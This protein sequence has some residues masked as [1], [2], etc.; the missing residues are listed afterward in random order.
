ME[1]NKL[2]V[3][4]QGRPC[5]DIVLEC[6]FKKLGESIRNFESANRKICI[7]TDSTVGHFYAEQIQT[8]LSDYASKV[9]VF[10]FP[11]GEAQKNLTT[12]QSL[13]EFLI[14]ESFDRNDLLVAL[15]GGVTGDLTG[16]TAATYL[17]GVRFVQIPTSLLAM[18]DSSIGGK[19]GVDLK[20]YKNMVGAFYQPSLVYINVSVLNT[21]SHR[22]YCSGFGEIIKHCLIKDAVFYAWLSEN[23]DKLLNLDTEPVMEMVYRSL[24]VKKEVVE[25]DTKEAGER[26]LLNF[27]H[28]IGHAVEKLKDFKFLHGECV[29]IGIVASAYISWKREKIT[30]S[31]MKEIVNCLQSFQLPVATSGITTSD[32]LDAASKDKK[33]DAGKIRF[34]LLDAVGSAVIDTTVSSDEMAEACDF[35]L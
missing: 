6:D 20:G 27:G 2:N 34:I 28:T 17:R 25:R 24:L 32:I 9:V 15:G 10:T 3:Q 33:M 29:S 11:A 14:L 22:E 26:A 16:F 8:E 1:R 19:T 31:E 12:V 35:I 7:V 21:L 30:E 13:Y 18:V 4:Y 5:Y 23:K